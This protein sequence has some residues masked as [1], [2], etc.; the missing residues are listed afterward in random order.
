MQIDPLQ[1]SVRLS[2]RELA[3]FRN[4]ALEQGHGRNAWRAAIGQEWHRC[5]EAE[6]RKENTE[7]RFEQSVEATW[8][9]RDWEFQLLGR[10]DQLI[11]LDRGFLIREIKTIR[12]HL[13]AARE[14]LLQAYPDHFAQTSIYHA[15]LKMLPNYQEHSI[16]SEL[17]FINIENGARQSV[18]LE[19][20]DLQLFIDRLDSLIPFLEERRES[21]LRLK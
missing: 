15:L 16:E 7:A 17:L 4:Q 5:A 12:S 21:R 13:P 19:T 8:R 2:V 3:V 14:S 6:T 9:H 10:I 1:R 11:P 20:K 18:R